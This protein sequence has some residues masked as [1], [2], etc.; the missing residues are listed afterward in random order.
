MQQSQAPQPV[1]TTSAS[2]SDD[3]PCRSKQ[4]RQQ[5]GPQH[6][7]RVRMSVWS[8]SPRSLLPSQLLLQPLLLLSS[9]AAPLRWAR[10]PTGSVVCAP[11]AAGEAPRRSMARARLSSA[12]RVVAAWRPAAGVRS[13]LPPL[14][15]PAAGWLV[16]L[17][18]LRGLAHALRPASQRQPATRGRQR[19]KTPSTSAERLH[20]WQIERERGARESAAN[21]PREAAGRAIKDQPGAADRQSLPSLRPSSPPV[22]PLSVVSKEAPGRPALSSLCCVGPPAPAPRRCPP[23]SVRLVPVCT[24][25]SP[26]SVPRAAVALWLRA[27]LS[28]AQ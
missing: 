6:L 5:Q 26:T 9:S 16:A 11:A 21:P 15:G 18:W 13:L 25:G 3:R 24:A 20:E 1:Q 2:S 23:Q 19:G 7:P 4:R 8:D 28:F 10:R 17:A 27:A 14:I 12:P 22:R